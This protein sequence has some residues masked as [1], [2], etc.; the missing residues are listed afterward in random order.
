MSNLLALARDHL[1][2]MANPAFG[3]AVNEEYSLR[4][5]S[6]L[7][8]EGNLG[9]L[10][11]ELQSVRDAEVL[12]SHGWL[13]LLGWARAEQLRLSE[14]L[15]IEVFNRWSNVFLKA[16]VLEVGVSQG[17]LATPQGLS[18][19]LARVLAVVTHTEDALRDD[20]R[21]VA[22]RRAEEALI[23]LLHVETTATLEAAKVLLGREWAGQARLGDFF[24]ATLT[25][26]EP[27]ARERWMAA[28]RPREDDEPRFR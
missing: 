11:D 23:A 19:F 13:W 4:L 12:T 27:D 5:A 28:L 25:T 7:Q 20:E 10:Q 22:T 2:R 6:L 14:D 16:A 1:D 26:L 18:P 15:L 3:A 17:D 24:S 21:G 9:R 8:Q